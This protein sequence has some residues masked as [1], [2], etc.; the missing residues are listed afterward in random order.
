M[1]KLSKYTESFRIDNHHKYSIS[2][3]ELPNTPTQY[4]QNS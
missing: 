2:P 1:T 4:G 3:W